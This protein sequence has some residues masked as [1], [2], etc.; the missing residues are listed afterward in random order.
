MQH[1]R[2]N[3]LEQLSLEQL[4]RRTSQ[5]WQAHGTDLLPLWVAEMDVPLAPPIAA[6]CGVRSIS[7]TRAT[8]RVGYADA[9]AGFAA[10]RWNWQISRSPIPG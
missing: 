3:P 8:R 1:A 10:A 9:V 2:R 4:R 5:K 7:V 6:R